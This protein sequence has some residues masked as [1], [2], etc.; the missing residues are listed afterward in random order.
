[1]RAEAAAQPPPEDN[2]WH[3]D[4][5]DKDYHAN[6]TGDDG[7]HDEYP[8]QDHHA[9]DEIPEIEPSTPAVDPESPSPKD[10]K[11]DT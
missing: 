3:D 10:P 4:S 2:S 6:E 8:Q 9:T 7:W 1:L 11:S 5:P